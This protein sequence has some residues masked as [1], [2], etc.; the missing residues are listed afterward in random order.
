MDRTRKMT[1]MPHHPNPHKPSLV[2]Q[3]PVADALIHLLHRARRGGAEA[4]LLQE[5]NSTATVRHTLGSAINSVV[6]TRH[7]RLSGTLQSLGS[8]RS[9]IDQAAN[10]AHTNFDYA[11]VHDAAAQQQ[12]RAATDPGCSN[13]AAL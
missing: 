4:P 1:T 10:S 3:S 11:Q 2:A 7:A 9:P 12:M 8:Q 5:C 6:F 13:R